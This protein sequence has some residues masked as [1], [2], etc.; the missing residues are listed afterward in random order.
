M[1]PVA[2][3]IAGDGGDQHPEEPR[4]ER[5]GRRFGRVQRPRRKRSYRRVPR[6][7]PRP[8]AECGVEQLHH[9]HGAD[10]Q[11]GPSR[12]WKALLCYMLGM[13]MF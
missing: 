3:N 11:R 12:E 9:A 2:V 8:R 4:G 1:F 13:V 10:G 6:D 5:H 7:G